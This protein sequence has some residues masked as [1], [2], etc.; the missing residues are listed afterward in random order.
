MV[1]NGP[2]NLQSTVNVAGAALV[3][4]GAMS[5]GD[6][7]AVT[8]EG[9]LGGTGTINRGVA[10]NFGTLTPGDLG[11]GTLTVNNSVS[12]TGGS[13]NIFGVGSSLTSLLVTGSLGRAPTPRST[14]AGPSTPERTPLPAMGA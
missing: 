8:V 9:T 10:V 14:S 5:A 13:L 7:S 11:A 3:I 12:L 4:N 2:A 6:G 1:I